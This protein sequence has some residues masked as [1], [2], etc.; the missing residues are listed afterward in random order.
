MKHGRTGYG[1][2][3]LGR[4]HPF[5]RRH[6]FD[7]CEAFRLLRD[8]RLRRRSASAGFHH[9]RQSA[10]AERIHKQ[11]VQE[12][13]CLDLRIVRIEQTQQSHACVIRSRRVITCS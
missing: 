10:A 6:A 9:W 2:G 4:R 1:H 3:R 5:P 7:D 13:G 12:E 11:P 8:N